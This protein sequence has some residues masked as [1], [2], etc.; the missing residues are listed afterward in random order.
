MPTCSVRGDG[1]TPRRGWHLWRFASL[2]PS[3]C[4][5]PP[6]HKVMG[7]HASRA[8]TPRRGFSAIGSFLIVHFRLFIPAS[9][10]A[11]LGKSWR[12]VPPHFDASAGFSC[13]HTPPWIRAVLDNR[14]PG[15]IK[16]RGVSGYPRRSE[17]SPFFQ[18]PAGPAGDNRAFDF[19]CGAATG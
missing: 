6:I 5:L 9:R 7:D 4:R 10:L 15:L 1:N 3:G 13:W 11:V 14:M 12:R 8:A 18:L 16:F 19:W 2:I 17:E